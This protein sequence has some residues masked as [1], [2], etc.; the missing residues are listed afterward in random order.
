MATYCCSAPNSLAICSWRLSTKRC[1]GMKRSLGAPAEARLGR[2]RLERA[3]RE[4]LGHRRVVVARGRG[5]VG[6]VRVEDRGQVLD[7]AATRAQLVLATAVGAD[8][9]L[10]AVVL[11]L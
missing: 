9:A 3:R 6:R 7:L 8:A 11:R 5:V 2:L 1:A 4:G 10:G